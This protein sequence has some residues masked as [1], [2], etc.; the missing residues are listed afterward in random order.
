MSPKK[1]CSKLHLT[2]I[3]VPFNFLLL[4]LFVVY[5]FATKIFLFIFIFFSINATNATYSVSWHVENESESAAWKYNFFSFH[6]QNSTFGSRIHRLVLFAERTAENVSV[7]GQ[8]VACTDTVFVGFGLSV[9]SF[10]STRVGIYSHF[11]HR[12]LSLYRAL[13]KSKKKN[14]LKSFHKLKLFFI[15]CCTYG[16]AGYILSA[17]MEI[18]LKALLVWNVFLVLDLLRLLLRMF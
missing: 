2:L 5:F 14:S 1:N 8:L 4:F 15:V 18:I 11:S 9:C 3:F 12:S 7:Y 13:E 17:W 6:P 10:C 16:C